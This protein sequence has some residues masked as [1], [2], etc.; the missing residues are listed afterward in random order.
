[1]GES[2]A[3]NSHQLKHGHSL[4]T[5]TSPTYR[6]WVNMISRCRYECTPGYSDYGGRGIAVCQKWQMFSGFLEDM[7]ERPSAQ[8]SIERIDCNGNYEQSNC[9]WILRSEQGRNTR[10][11]VRVTING[12][13]KCVTEWAE[14]SG[15]PA[16]T[17]LWRIRNGWP[18]E[19]AV[20]RAT[21]RG[22]RLVNV[23]RGV[24]A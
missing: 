14:L 21:K 13:T 5:Y 15:V 2:G 8:H 4:S 23:L 3:R 17:A 19:I 6:T 24:E 7:G 22:T 1:M 18:P 20:T 16:V 9:K 12:Q 11:T 10:Q